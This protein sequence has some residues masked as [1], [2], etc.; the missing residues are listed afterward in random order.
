MRVMSGRT[1]R[2]A[3]LHGPGDLRVE[4]RPVP[5]PEGR[6]ALVEVHRCGICGTDVHLV[7]EGWGRPG[8]VGGHEWSG[9]VRAV[10]PEAQLVAPG[11]AVVGGPAPGCGTCPPCRRHRIALCEQRDTPGTAERDG[12]FAEYVCVDERSLL[13]VPA[14]LDL[15]TAALAEPLAVAVHAVTVSGA[16][17]GDRALV[18]GAG[19]I[20]ALVVLAL[21]ARGVDDIVV[22]EPHAG[23][24]DVA[25][26][27]GATA[28]VTPD[29]LDVPSI[30]EPRRLVAD[31][32]DV[33]VECSGRAA[34]MAAACTQLGP[35]GR[36]VLVGS[37]I[38]PPRFDP[39]RILLNE[40]EVVGAFEYDPDGM[41]AAVEL[42]A[43]GRVDVA[44]AVEPHDVGLE[45][46]AQA[47]DGLAAGRITGKV[48]VAPHPE[49]EA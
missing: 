45:D 13:A 24:R 18:T 38:E 33:A 48:L 28:V 31:R 41:V 1:M 49:E 36:L 46:L 23:R 29:Q 2:A 27:L 35:G 11:D 26:R 8:S 32:V 37:G 10:G 5:R 7:V 40:L 22:S 39:N 19:P 16:A 25:A 20:G 44:P 42:L 43:S 14:G 9:H 30:A 3:V 12:A 15:R 47:L 4:D 6:E 21:R 17:A 34:A